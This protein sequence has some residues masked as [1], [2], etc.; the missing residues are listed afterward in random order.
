MTDAVGSLA[1]LNLGI[2]I[3]AYW[4]EESI[5]KVMHSVFRGFYKWVTFHLFAL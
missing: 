2:I 5:E 4:Q 1:W 3:D